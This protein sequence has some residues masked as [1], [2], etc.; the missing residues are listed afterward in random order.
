MKFI[1]TGGAGYIGSHMVKYLRSMN[2]EVVALDN[3][4]TGNK[5]A[6]GNCDFFQ[7]DL[8]D[9]EQLYNFLKN[10]NYD[11]IFHF[12]AKSLTAESFANPEMYERNN[13]EATQ[14]VIEVAK[15]NE[16]K[17]LI[18]SS[19]AAVYGILSN[20]KVKETHPTFPIS[21]YG[22][23]KLKCEKIINSSSKKYGINSVNLRYFNVAGADP[24]GQI[25]ES[26]SP[27]THLIPIILNSLLAHGKQV[28]VYGN[29]YDTADGTCIR[30]YVHV[31]DIVTAH[32]LALK[33]LMKN[34]ISE[35]YNL[36]NGNGFSVLEIISACEKVSKKKVNFE[37]TNKRNG[38]PAILIADYKKAE[39]G[40]NWRPQFKDIH[41]II[42]TAWIWHKSLYK[43]KSA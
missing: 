2:H 22:I 42:E 16:I 36:G 3:L 35:T 11:A 27:E 14:N 20:E 8:L 4:S 38:D 43:F 12:A 34:G 29:D 19:S 23:T 24:S 28:K 37:I 10:K 32:Y 9:F 1:V 15:R 33:S 39:N 17:N 18:F 26:H 41:K 25:G 21:P 13:I 40:L 5:W 7:V 31:N 6:L 30:D